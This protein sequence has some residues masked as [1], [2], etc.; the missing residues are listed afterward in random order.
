MQ[1][2]RE[3]F[4]DAEDKQKAK[5]AILAHLVGPLG[6]ASCWRCRQGFGCFPAMDQ[7]S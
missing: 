2:P 6:Q 1:A 7:Y 3:F 5:T 4:G